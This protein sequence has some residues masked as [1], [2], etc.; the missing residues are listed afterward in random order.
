[1][2]IFEIII[3]LLFLQYFITLP[4][5][6]KK[7]GLTSWHG[8]IPVLQWLTWL[9]MLKRPWYWV[10]ILL[11]PGVNL[12]MLTILNVETGI[13][14]NKRSM[15][16]QWFFGGLPWIALF[17][18]SFRQK[19]AEFIGPRDWTNRKKSFQ[20]EWGEAILFAVIAASVIRSF[21]FEAFTIPTG[22]M[23]GSMLVGDYLFVS[24]MSYGPKIQ[25]TPLSLPFIHNAIPGGMTNSYLEWIQLPNYRLPG[26]GDVERYD[27]VV[28]NFPHGDSV[29][30]HP[31]T[32]GHDY[33]ALL[34]NV[35][36]QMA[37]SPE[38]Y[39]ADKVTYDE[40]AKAY[41]QK[42]L[43]A[44]IKARPIDKEENYIKRCVALPGETIEIRDRQVFL[45][46]EAMENP[47][48]LQYNYTLKLKNPEMIS[49]I[50]EKLGLTNVDFGQERNG[51][52][53]GKVALTQGEVDQLTALNVVD[54]MFLESQASNQGQLIVFPNS[55]Q[56]P[57]N[58]W[59]QDNYGP[60]TL[61]AK[62]KTYD[63]NLE[64]LPIYERVIS[65]YEGNDLE[66][67]DGQILI[68]GEVVTSYTFAQDY[69]WMMG[70]NRHNSADSRMWGFVPESHVVGKAVFTWFS[71]Q[72]EAQHGESKIRWD[73]MFQVPK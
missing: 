61:P 59:D 62:G 70:D 8:F 67:R 68:N 29:V 72:N 33:Y 27:P 65:V 35:G 56:A 44:D 11:V 22:S 51:V 58:T 42:Q 46:G 20:R 12:L 71:K 63:L 60:V 41:Y 36:K 53:Y 38:A 7:A 9:K 66:V 49:K 19:E 26:F 1:M 21:F 6:F 73:R 16:E 10:F 37:G 54:T 2:N 47:D 57:Y 31:S 3:V 14:F 64:N 34:R 69:Y 30:A 15:K 43:K 4:G 45:D 17:D 25:Q 48:G 40:R 13:A 28:F 5:I 50:I 52:N 23:E 39:V 18:L 32:A 55:L 24:K